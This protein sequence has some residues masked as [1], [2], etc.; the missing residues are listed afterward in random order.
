VIRGARGFVDAHSIDVYSFTPGEDAHSIDVHSF[1]P[2]E[3]AHS[4]DV[5]SFTPGED[6]HSIDVCS[7]LWIYSSAGCLDVWICIG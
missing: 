2:G 7:F 3:D 1:T 6:A 5:Y 4:I